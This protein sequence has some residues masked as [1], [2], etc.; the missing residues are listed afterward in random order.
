MERIAITVLS[1]GTINSQNHTITNRTQM[2][3]EEESRRAA[4]VCENC[5]TAHSV[6]IGPVGDVR[7]IGTGQGTGCTCGNGNFRVLSDDKDLLT[8]IETT[9]QQRTE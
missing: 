4:A 8:D 3:D 5:G 6:R 1:G 9:E 7:P 2:D